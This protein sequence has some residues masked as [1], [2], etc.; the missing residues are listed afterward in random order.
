MFNFVCRL[1]LR[2]SYSVLYNLLIIQYTTV[3]A[4]YVNHSSLQRQ[5]ELEE[6]L[7]HHL[8]YTELILSRGIVPIR[9][10]PPHPQI[11]T[12]SDATAP[13]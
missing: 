2:I 9:M 7:Y 3:L 6:Y 12:L 4:L 10:M 5:H 1:H 11:Y 8:P 13:S